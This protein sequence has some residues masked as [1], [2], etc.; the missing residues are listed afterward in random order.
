MNQVIISKV[1]IGM[2]GDA[3]GLQVGDQIKQ[4]GGHNVNHTNDIVK[5]SP[6]I[7]AQTIDVVLLRNKQVISIRIQPANWG[8]KLRMEKDPNANFGIQKEQTRNSSSNHTKN[9]SNR[10]KTELPPFETVTP[11]TDNTLTNIFLTA[12]VF[13]LAFGVFLVI[14][15]MSFGGCF[16]GYC[17]EAAT[18]KVA[19]GAAIVSVAF[20]V[21]RNR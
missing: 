18:P 10:Y 9:N 7:T 4:F 16:K 13:M 21:S 20:Y 8:I 3:A 12:L 2:A 1:Q 15:Q 5:L 11:P 17:I 14:N 6:K 19:F